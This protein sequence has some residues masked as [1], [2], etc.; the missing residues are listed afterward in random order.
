MRLAVENHRAGTSALASRLIQCRFATTRTWIGGQEC[1][2][3]V[4]GV[5]AVKIGGEGNGVLWLTNDF[6]GFPKEGITGRVQKLVS[7]AG[8]SYV[9]AEAVHVAC[10]PAAVAKD[11]RLAPTAVCRITQQI[12]LG[13]HIE[14]TC[15]SKLAEAGIGGAWA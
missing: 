2:A 6:K 5:G 14:Q 9:A 8:A 13:R 15:V 1:L 10:K 7:K 3:V 4:G 11:D 12:T